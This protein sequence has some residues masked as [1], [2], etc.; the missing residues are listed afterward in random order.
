MK[1]ELL[2]ILQHSLGVDQYGRGRQYRN[3][4][5]AG[6]KDVDFCNELVAL[7]FMQNR[8]SGQLTGGSD[9]YTVT[10]AGR[11]SMVDNSPKP[12]K[13][14]KSRQRYLHYLEI[15]GGF[16][17]GEYLKNGWYKQSEGRI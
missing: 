3:H 2:H 15:D 4:F 9:C 8:G 6:G 10:D 16:S 14:S 7:G 13:V 17:F 5:V 11:R 12:P 1:A